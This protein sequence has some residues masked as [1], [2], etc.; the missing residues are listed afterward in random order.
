MPY[1]YL[2]RGKQY[3]LKN[4]KVEEVNYTALDLA[5]IAGFVD[6]EGYMGIQRRRRNRNLKL[7][8]YQA[9]FAIGNTNKDIL[10][11]IQRLLGGSVRQRTSKPNCLPYFIWRV[12]SKHSV[13]ILECLFPYLKVKKLQAESIIKFQNTMGTKGNLIPKAKITQRAIYYQ[14][15][16]YFN[17]PGEEYAIQTI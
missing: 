13:D 10:L 14:E 2:R 11:Y 16:R 3:G 12:V 8:E 7:I 15:V 6:G 4:L 5:Y 1:K 9:Y 17:N